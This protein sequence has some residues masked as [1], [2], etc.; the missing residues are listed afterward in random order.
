MLIFCR[1]AGAGLAPGPIRNR[2][3]QQNFPALAVAPDSH[4][5]ARRES[6]GV[7]ATY[8]CVAQPAARSTERL[9]RGRERSR[10][11]RGKYFL[12]SKLQTRALTVRKIFP[13]IVLDSV[14]QRGGLKSKEGRL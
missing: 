12:A 4:Q 7:G 6:H 13:S 1:A 14:I 8:Q 10:L 3:P 5:S 9:F 11:R 2:H